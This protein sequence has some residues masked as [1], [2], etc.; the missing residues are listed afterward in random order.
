MLQLA[1]QH[2]NLVTLEEGAIKGGAGS[3]VNEV[4]MAA[5]RMTPVLNLGLPDRF[6]SQGTQEEVRRDLA[7]DADGI[8]AAIERWL[9]Q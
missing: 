6:I 7:L 3:G 9:N 2:D 8:Q 5:R 4:L 1:E